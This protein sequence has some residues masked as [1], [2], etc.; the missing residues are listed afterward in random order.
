MLLYTFEAGRYAPEW[1]HLG[2][3]QTSSALLV[4]LICRR[5]RFFK[6]DYL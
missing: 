5:Q 3:G 6:E 2:L 4:E 1:T